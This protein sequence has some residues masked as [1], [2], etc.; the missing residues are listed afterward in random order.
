[1]ETP[2]AAAPPPGAT[3]TAI[4][5]SGPAPTPLPSPGPAELA[6]FNKDPAMKVLDV[7]DWE[8]TLAAQQP[9]LTDTKSF[10]VRAHFPFPVVKQEEWKL[11]ITGLVDKPV[12]LTYD[13][14]TKMPAKKLTMWIECAGDGRGRF[15]PMASGG[16]WQVGAVGNAEWMGVALNDVLAMASPKSGVVDIVC[17]G[18]GNSQW[19]RGLNWAKAKDPDT[20]LVWQ[21]NGAPLRVEQGFPVRLIVPGYPGVAQV[22][23]ITNI[24]LINKPY[25]GYFN[26][27]LYTFIDANGKN[28]G[29]LTTMPVKSIITSLAPNASVKSGMQAVSGKAWSGTGGITKVEVSA[30]SGKTWNA[31][32]ITEQAGQ[33]SWYAFEYAWDA[34]DGNAVLTSRATDAKGNVQPEIPPWNVNGYQYNGWWMVPMTVGAQAA[35]ANTAAPVSTIGATPAANASATTGGNTVNVVEKDFAIALDKSSVS[36]GSITFA[37]KNDG[38]SPHNLAFP[39]LN[40]VSET[41]DA[42]KTS[43]LTLDLKPGTYT[44]ICNIP[45]HDL[46]GMKGTLTVK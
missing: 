35:A 24:D 41:L 6:A 14:L 21:M 26:T 1:W 13:Q 16:Q 9:F 44:Y 3:V 17:G 25:D 20:M 4:P 29:Q 33:W 8:A 22:K 34:K 40:K 11:T 42:G 32:K 46:L 2:L 43:T 28:L 45:G 38:P 37:I 10:F 36:A 19:A 31:A 15:K 7:V 23:W 39:D 12:T 27:T 18:A 5:A 30:D